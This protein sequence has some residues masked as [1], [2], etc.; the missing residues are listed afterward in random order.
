M[1]R[2]ILAISVGALCLSAC[3][4]GRDSLLTVAPTPVK[5]GQASYS[6]NEQNSGVLKDKAALPT[7]NKGFPVN[8]DWV[9]GYDALLATYGSTLTPPRKAGDRD[10]IVK[11]GDHY[12]IT[13]AVMVRQQVLNSTRRSNLRQTKEQ[14]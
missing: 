3:T 7:Y 9:D 6:G 11:E 1:K 8:Q 14:Q 2:L 12:R 5:S 4:H 13:D 10:G